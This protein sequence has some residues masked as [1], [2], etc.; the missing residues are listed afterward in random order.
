MGRRSSPT[1][2]L[3]LFLALPCPSV[4]AAQWPSDEAVS[5]LWELHRLPRERVVE[6]FQQRRR[7]VRFGLQGGGTPG[8]WAGQRLAAC[9]EAWGSHAS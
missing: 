4:L 6:W 7:R 8:Q 3:T 1:L 2:L 9:R 5:G